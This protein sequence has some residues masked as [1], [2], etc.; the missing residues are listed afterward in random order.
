MLLHII[1]N[2]SIYHFH[3]FEFL[4]WSYTGGTHSRKK[5]QQTT[6]CMTENVNVATFGVL[7]IIVTSSGGWKLKFFMR[8]KNAIFGL[9]W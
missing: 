3:T 2:P 7:L 9:L 8:P 1:K 5:N 4:S 6:P